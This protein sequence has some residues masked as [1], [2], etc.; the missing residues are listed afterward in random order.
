MDVNNTGP[1]LRSKS[2]TVAISQLQRSHFSLHSQDWMQNI[3]TSQ[4]YQGWSLDDRNPQ[5]IESLMPKWEWAY[6]H[7]FRVQTDGWD[8]IPDGPVLFV[9]AHNGGLAAPDLP[10][11]MF[12]W[13][14]RFGCERPVYGLMHPKVWR[15]FPKMAQYAAQAGAIQAHPKMAIAALQK[16]ASVLVYPG[17]APDGF[18]PHR[19]RHQIHFSGRTGFIKLALRESIPIIPAIS[20]GAHDTLI[21]LADCYEQV[22]QLHEKGMPW[23]F[24]TDPEVFPIYLGLPWGIAL[25]PLPNLPWPAQIHTRVCEPIIFERY[26]R[27]TLKDQAYVD[28]CYATVVR[29]MQLALDDLIAE[30]K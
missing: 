10:M 27:E 15:V 9:G 6:R 16:R 26:G 29:R 19:M 24:E 22:R 1:E 3:Q 30:C 7:Y 17:G 14:R 2:E 8:H 23:L 21:V 5:I 12:D 25:G 13:F 28:A 18:K 11:F 4:R 20:W